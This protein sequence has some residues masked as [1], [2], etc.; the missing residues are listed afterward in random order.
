MAVSIGASELKAKNE[1]QQQQSGQIQVELEALWAWMCVCNVCVI[2]VCVWL[3][4]LDG[5]ER[6]VLQMHLMPLATHQH[7]TASTQHWATGARGKARTSNATT[8]TH[9]GPCAG[10]C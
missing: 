3:T 1:Q 7:V 9:H 2:R 6:L 5:Q 10:G 4:H 8:A